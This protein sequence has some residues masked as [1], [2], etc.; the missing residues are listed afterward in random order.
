MLGIGIMYW[1]TSF[2]ALIIGMI[3]KKK[4]MLLLFLNLL[5]WTALFLTHSKSAILWNNLPFMDYFQFPWRFNAL[6]GIFFSLTV[7]YFAIIS[8]SNY[9]KSVIII[10]FTL[11][12]LIFHGSFF[13]PDKWLN[14]TDT[15]KLSGKNWDLATTISINDYLPIYTNL[16]PAKKALDK[17]EVISGKV[18]FINIEKGTNWQ[19]WKLFASDNSVVQAQLFYFPNWKVYID[20]KNTPIDYKD[21]N[22]LITFSIQMGMH[23][24]DLRLT[25]TPIRTTGN[26]I[27]LLGFPVFLFIFR[28]YK[29]EE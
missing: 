28:K 12:L 21:Y 9:F 20:G 26:A 8:V 29:Y 5:A 16:S 2:V 23:T 18:D 22:G 4:R 1:F 27:T 7:G 25:D 17:P 19:K 11:I 10:F 24:V 13:H 15:D 6:A 3:L 14:I